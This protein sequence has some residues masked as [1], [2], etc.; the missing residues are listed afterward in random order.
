MARVWRDGQKKTVHIYRLLTAGQNKPFKV[1][2]TLNLYI[3]FSALCDIMGEG[4]PSSTTCCSAHNFK[5][6][7]REQVQNGVTFYF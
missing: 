2:V 4:G 3:I 5:C 1:G 7:T 6:A